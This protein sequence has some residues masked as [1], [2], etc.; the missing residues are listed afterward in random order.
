M[1]DSIGPRNKGSS[2]RGGRSGQGP[3][4]GDREPTGNEGDRRGISRWR[5]QGTPVILSTR[6]GP[7]VLDKIDVEKIQR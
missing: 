7:G 2:E 5:E 3:V 6:Y 1:A 4:S